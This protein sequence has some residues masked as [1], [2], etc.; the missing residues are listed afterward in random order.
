MK[1]AIVTGATGFIGYKL[2]KKLLSHGYCITLVARDRRKIEN[3]IYRQENIFVIE[4]SIE[5]LV[6]SDFDIWGYDVFFN[7]AWEGVSTESK[8]KAN[9]Q[10]ANIG[11]CIHAAEVANAVKCEK[12]ISAGTVAEYA[13]CDNVMDFES[14]QA[15]NDM[16]GAAKVSAH[17]FLDVK[18]RQ[19]DQDFIWVVLPS[20]YGEGRTDH[21]IINYTIC[22]LL[23][24]E[25]PKYGELTQLWDFLYV[26]DVVDALIL[27]GEK[28][29]KENVY[30]IGS[31]QYRP[32]K[33]YIMMIRDMINPKLEIGIGYNRNMAGKAFSSCVDI[34]NLVR[35]TGFQPNISFEEGIKRT[36]EWY[37]TRI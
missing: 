21:N 34:Y 14:R 13:L 19:L 16:Y 25:V 1:R 18:N 24:G 32:L 3:H 7:L 8:N 36:I 33:E 20:T 37:R 11:M 22:S 9:I 2:V 30:G 10:L 6:P 17:Y 26:D 29:R 5:N 23:K 27:I 35:D 28:G 15:P 12:F 31:G 4:K